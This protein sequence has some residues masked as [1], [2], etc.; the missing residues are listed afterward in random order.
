MVGWLANTAKAQYY[1]INVET[2]CWQTGSVDSTI[3]GAYISAAATTKPTEIHYFTIGAGTAVTAVTVSGGTLKKGACESTD[4]V[5]INL[6][7]VISQLDSLYLKQRSVETA[8]RT[9]GT[10]TV[11]L[12]GYTNGSIT[13]IA[14]KHKDGTLDTIGGPLATFGTTW[15]PNLIYLTLQNEGGIPCTYGQWSI[16]GNVLTATGAVTNYDSLIVSTPS[17]AFPFTLTNLEYQSVEIVKITDQ[18]GNVSSVKVWSM[19][20]LT[21]YRI[22]EITYTDCPTVQDAEIC[23]WYGDNEAKILANSDGTFTAVYKNSTTIIYQADPDL[24]NCTYDCYSDSLVI[25]TELI[26]NTLTN[27]TFPTGVDE[28]VIFNYSSAFITLT[29]NVGAQLI[30]PSSNVFIRHN[31]LTFTSIAATSGTFGSGDELV[32][33][34]AVKR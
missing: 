5:N 12:T 21:E 14:I 4:S 32:F 33:N 24:I 20:G 31:N 17:Q 2:L 1:G 6:K 27:P 16:N 7:A 19:D 22:C 11:D 28:I 9:F 30:G 13:V 23:C 18:L 25:S 3:Y 34:Y 29:T 10:A 8:C 15:T 26:A